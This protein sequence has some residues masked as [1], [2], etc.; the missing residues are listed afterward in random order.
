MTQNT[1][2]RDLF[3]RFLSERYREEIAQLAQI[4]GDTTSLVVDFSDL[5]SF[6]PDLADDVRENPDQLL[7]FMEE[8]VTLVDIPLDVSLVGVTVRL[9]G[10]IDEHCYAPGEVRKEQAGEY[11]GVTG[12]L[13]RV[14]TT[15]DMPDTL[16]YDC[17]RPTRP[18]GGRRA[19]T[20]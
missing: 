13:E 3:V 10:M 1:E 14:T 11:I 4:F 16:V 7:P 9:T 2:I 8:A 12:T 17:R 19:R 20:A 18:V 15:S 6:D 5:W